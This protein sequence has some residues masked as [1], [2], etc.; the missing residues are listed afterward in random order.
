MATRRIELKGFLA[1]AK[2]Y[3][4]DEYKGNKFWAVDFY[5]KDGEEWDKLKKSG[6]TLRAKENTET[7]RV[8][9]NLPEGKYVRFRRPV[10][11]MIRGKMTNFEGPTVV[12]DNKIVGKWIQKSDESYE[13]SGDMV[14]LGNGSKVVVTVE[15]Y[16]TAMGPGHR[17]SKIDVVDLIVY[18]RPEEPEAPEGTEGE[19]REVA[20]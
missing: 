1:F 4:P 14:L 13:F 15:V 3:V 10:A 7:N 16:D 9:Y 12:V 2:T 11:K 18:E 8:K 20:W 17:L 19:T 6:L 5:P